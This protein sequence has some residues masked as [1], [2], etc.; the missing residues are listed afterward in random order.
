M[1]SHQSSR[2][3]RHIAL[4]LSSRSLA[5]LPGRAFSAAAPKDVSTITTFRGKRFQS[6]AAVQQEPQAPPPQKKASA[7]PFVPSAERQYEF[8]QNVEIT[9]QGVAVVRFDNLSKPV[10][11]ISFALADEA[12]KLWAKE[13]ENNDAVKAVVFTSAKPNMFIAGA[14]IFDIQTMEDKS[15]LTSIIAD[16]LAF[17]QSM[18]K[19]GVPLV[20]AIDGPALGGGLEWALWCD[21]RICTDNP[22][23]KVCRK[24]KQTIAPADGSSR[25]YILPPC[26][27]S[28][29]VCVR[30]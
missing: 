3:M 22:K 15:Q 21:Y 10:N 28:L 27:V 25:V 13:I 14:D 2:A 24:H 19:K 9:P 26:P 12:K 23:T 30:L 17:F 8:F 6:T 1:L 5:T 16:G 4:R 29:F 7:T 18:R 11:T 20:A